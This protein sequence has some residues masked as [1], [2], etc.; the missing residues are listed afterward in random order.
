MSISD[1]FQREIDAPTK[2]FSASITEIRDAMAAAARAEELRP[3]LGSVLNHEGPKFEL[4]LAREFISNRNSYVPTLAQACYVLAYG[5][6]ENLIREIVTRAARAIN[7]EVVL[8]RLPDSLIQ[9]NVH[10]V[11]RLLSRIKN[12]VVHIQ[13]D[14]AMVGRNLASLKANDGRY[15][16]EHTAF[17]Y[18]H[19]GLSSDGL[20]RLLSRIGLQLDW[21]EFGRSAGFKSMFQESKVAKC[22]DKVQES[23]DEFVKH[24]NLIAHTGSSSITMDQATISS[25]CGF[26]MEFQVV[27]IKLVTQTLERKYSD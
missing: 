24:R 6:Y 8:A 25:L 20:D 21:N 13:L 10:Q 12:P 18:D 23:L 22:K 9:E 1:S 16:L 17:A 19:G 4:G 14:Y 5:H 2:I 27:L 26:L 7:Y 11:G 3:R 15:V